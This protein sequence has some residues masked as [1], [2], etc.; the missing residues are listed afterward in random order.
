MITS[1]HIIPM[2]KGGGSDVS[3]R[4]PMC[5]PCNTIK[6]SFE[7][8]EMGKRYL[9]SV[10]C[11]KKENRLKEMPI[12]IAYFNKKILEGDIAQDWARLLKTTEDKLRRL[13]NEQ[14]Y[15]DVKSKSSNE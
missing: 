8:V 5:S 13:Q 15:T 11:T 9:K 4:Q 12:R 2:S 10:E 6:G 14:S 7:S 3:N 1:D